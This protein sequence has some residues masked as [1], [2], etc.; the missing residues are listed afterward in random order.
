VHVS[1]AGLGPIHHVSTASLKAGWLCFS[2]L[3]FSPSYALL[4]EYPWWY[5][6]TRNTKELDHKRLL[7]TVILGSLS[8]CHWLF[9]CME[10][11]ARR[12]RRTKATDTDLY[13]FNSDGEHVFRSSMEQMDHSVEQKIIFGVQ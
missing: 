12:T 4:S 11:V 9:I 1:L 10:I 7:M 13:I 8:D 2:L 5:H 6:V 3:V